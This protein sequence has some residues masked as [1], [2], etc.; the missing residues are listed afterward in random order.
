MFIISAIQRKTAPIPSCA[1]ATLLYANCIIKPASRSVNR[2]Q[3][4]DLL[5]QFIATAAP[6][7]AE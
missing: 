5:R 4:R 2:L 1:A 7:V 6:D 3:H